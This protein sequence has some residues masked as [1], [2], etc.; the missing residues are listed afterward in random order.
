MMRIYLDNNAT[1]G[2]DPQVLE[3]MLL[4]SS[5][6][7][8]N[9]SSAHFF[10]QEAK[11]KLIRAREEIA[12]FFCVLPSELVFTSGGTEAMNFLIRGLYREKGHIISTEIEHSSVYNMLKHLEKQGAEVCFLPVGKWGAPLISQIEAAIQPHTHMLVLSAVNSETGV[13]LDLGAAARLA[14]RKGILLVVDGVALLGKELFSLPAGVAA[15]GF[16][17]HKIHGPKG[18]GLALVR[19]S[20]KIDPLLIGG[21][22]E[23][24]R[25]GGTENLAGILGLAKAI[26]LLKE[27]V[28]SHR[29]KMCIERDRL[30]AGIRHEVGEISINGE[31]PLI[32]NTVNL[33]FPGI[34]GEDLL[35]LL[36]QEGLAVSH[37]SACSS[38]A[39]EPSRVLINMGIARELARSA[40]RF[41]LSRWTTDEEITRAIAL[42][43]ALVKKLKN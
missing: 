16:S 7:P 29:E 34:S 12:N 28:E 33:S 24:S 2:L 30:I 38:G 31:G 21:P 42:T 23:S 20:V 8:L 4:D 43:G 22:Q 13:K 37:G 10:G 15:M 1:T 25:R 39:L 5:T 11:K 32:S 35:I 26:S 3:A 6:T 17:G 36:D 14:E 19:S 9:P 18:I 41:S 40:V 27:G